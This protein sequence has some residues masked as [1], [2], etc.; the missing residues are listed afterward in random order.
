MHLK[1]IIT[2]AAIFGMASLV[3]CKKSESTVTES[4]DELTV[5]VDEINNVIRT[6]D[7]LAIT[8]LLKDMYKWHA[9]DEL[10][11]DFDVYLAHPDDTI[12]AGIDQ[13][14]HSKRIKAIKSSD[15]FTDK[16]IDNYDKIASAIDTELKKGTAVYVVG[17][18]PPYGN[19]SDPWTHSQ[20]SADD[21]WKIFTL[22]D[23]KYKGENVDCV[24]S[25]KDYAYSFKLIKENGTFKIDEM[26][27]FNFKDFTSQLY[28]PS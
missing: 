1:L 5:P 27:G 9:K 19:E 26:E 18:F 15:F 2:L 28:N 11:G 6:D 17:E 13:E 7:S 10:T 12:Y 25:W 20:D 23:I 24:W 8:Q 4:N 16:F 3:S 14:A 21:Y 22:T